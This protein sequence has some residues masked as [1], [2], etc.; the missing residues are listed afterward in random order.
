MVLQHD[1]IPFGFTKLYKIVY[2]NKI[3]LLKS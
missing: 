3:L 2:N 1:G